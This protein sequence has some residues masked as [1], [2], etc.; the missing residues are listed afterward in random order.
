MEELRRKN[1]QYLFNP[2]SIGI[3]GASSDLNK[4]SGRPLAY[5]LRFAYPGAIYPINPKYEEIAGVRCYPTLEEVPEEIDIL[6]VIIPANEI[7]PNL[8]AGLAKG[9]KAA[10]IISGGFAEVGGKGRELQEALSAFAR[11]TGMLIYGPNTTGFL[12]LVNRSIA[13][14]SQSLEVIKEMV[15]GRTGLITQSGAFGAAIFVRAMRVG[16]GIS[17]WAATGNE[18]DLEFCDF[19]DYMADDPHTHVI[20]GFLAGVEDGEK[21][22]DGL[23]RAAAK[24]KPVVLLKVGGTEAGKR[25]AYSHTGAI[26]GSARAYD[27]AFQQKGVVVARDIDELID[28]SMALATTPPPK[29]KRVGIMTESGGGGVLLTE[30]CAELG[31][32]VSEIFGH[33][34]ERLKKVVPALGSVRNPVDLTGQSLSNPALVKGAIEVMVDSEDFDMVVPLLLMSEAT[35][36]RKVRD[37]LEILQRR[38]KDGKT[39]VVCWPEGPK[40]WIQHLV[41]KGVHVSVTPSRCARTLNALS[42]VAESQRR[43]KGED[44]VDAS[45]VS[46]LPGDRLERAMEVIRAAA[47]DGET[48]LTEHQAR[49]VLEAY[50]I[51]VVRGEL[52][53]SLKEAVLAAKTIGYPVAAKVI[54]PDIPH[55][56][57]A[58]VVALGISS[59]TRLRRVY[60]E[61]LERAKAHRPHARIHGVLIQEM[62]RDQGIE[63]IVGVSHEPPFG[64]TLLFGLGG[65]FVEVMRDVAIRVLPATRGDL[66]SMISQIR[67]YRILQGVRGRKPSDTGAILSILMKTACLGKEL[68]RVVAEVD[69]NPLFVLEEGKGAKALDALIS[70]HR[71]RET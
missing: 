62:V 35:A 32:E 39:V 1:L 68:A 47:R 54:S 12:S 19:L 4:V 45:S 48:R 58:G 71:Q 46:D 26:V 50:G 14:F 5:M 2:R 9:V 51:P 55:K 13:T 61:I 28:F 29:G 20:A 37:F 27:A 25:A 18:A 69:I 33:T 30:R 24:G 53:G 8:E 10:I 44:A 3:L 17:H 11:R 16:L 6:M 63:T 66:R 31:L 21:F 7:L 57:E 56:T 42:S 67:G 22:L 34:L 65:I 59:E 40:A 38:E 43:C 23:A 36:E 64:P 49:M 70:L 15:P 52:A 60:S 41:E